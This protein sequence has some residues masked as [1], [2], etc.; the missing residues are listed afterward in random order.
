MRWIDIVQHG[1]SEYHWFIVRVDPLAP[2]KLPMMDGCDV[3]PLPDDMTLEEEMQLYR[4]LLHP[5]SPF[6]LGFRY[7][8]TPAADDYSMSVIYH[9]DQFFRDGRGVLEPVPGAQRV[10]WP[11]PEDL[12]LWEWATDEMEKGINDVDWTD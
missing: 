6:G 11:Q 2:G 8:D 9:G 5:A 7:R 10:R 4:A 12:A 1:E 3:K